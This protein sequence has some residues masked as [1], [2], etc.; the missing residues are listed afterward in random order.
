MHYPEP[1]SKLIDSFMKLPGIGPKTAVRLAFFVLDMKEDD[2]LGFAKA[3]VNAKRDLAYCSVCGHIT[4]RDPCYI[5]DDSHRDQTVVC[6]VQ[7]PKDV[8]AMEKMK[9][10]QGVYHV[11]RGAIS[12]MEGIGPEDINIPQLLKRLHDET[13][14]EVILATNPNI[15]GEATAMY[16]SRLLKP[17][18]IKVTRIAHGLPVGGDLEYADEVTLS[19]ALEGRREV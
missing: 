10:Y 15:E 6:V 1:I 17:T 11:L 13:V 18:G 16:I 9:E 8:I 12:P 4:D 19:K 2:V 7:E 3:L 5:C 14:Q